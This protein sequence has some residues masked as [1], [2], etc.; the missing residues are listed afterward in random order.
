MRFSHFV[1][2]VVVVV[3]N[4]PRCL[5]GSSSS[6]G[7]KIEAFVAKIKTVDL[8]I[9]W[10]TQI[11]AVPVP[12]NES[13]SALAL[14]CDVVRA[15]GYIYIAG[16]VDNGAVIG[17]GDDPH[18]SFGSDDIF[19]PMLDTES[20]DNLWLKQVGSSG[21]DRVVHGGGV[22]SDKNGNAL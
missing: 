22:T 4:V 11:G 1:T 19:V 20:V 21:D 12:G 17:N 5:D 2:F 18:Q 16:N 3:V 7:N 8:D 10:S 9:E 6:R 15:A 14:G 13:S